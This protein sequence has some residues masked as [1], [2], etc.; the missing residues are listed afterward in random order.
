MSF[1]NGTNS[2]G[3]VDQE[4]RNHLLHIEEIKS[5]IVFDL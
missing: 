3:K 1:S 4:R 2:M 5:Y